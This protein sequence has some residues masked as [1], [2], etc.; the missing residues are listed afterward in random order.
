MFG[1]I[2]FIFLGISLKCSIKLA[3]IVLQRVYK[4]DIVLV[5][6]SISGVGRGRGNR[7]GA[8]GQYNNPPE[9]KPA[10]PQQPPQEQRPP[11]QHQQ[12]RQPQPNPQQTKPQAQ[13]QAAA[14]KRQQ[15]Q[16]PVQ[17]TPV[18]S[19]KRDGINY[20]PKEG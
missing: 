1:Q 6:F 16:R 17:S 10:A 7:P 8:N 2:S 15:Q 5:Q 9:Q 3:K 12:Q 18:T 14:Q 11:T 4:V 19:P 13:P 20:N